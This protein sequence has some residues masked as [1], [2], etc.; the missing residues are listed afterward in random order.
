[1]QYNR[2]RQLQYNQAE[3]C[4]VTLYGKQVPIEDETT[5]LG[6]K[7]NTKCQPNIDEKINLGQ[8]TAYSLV[9]AGFQGKSGLKQSIKAD[10]WRKYV[11]PKTLFWSGI[12]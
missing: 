7:I 5:H 6:I 10:M 1:M 9:G 4:H 2:L 12:L 3:E 8:R 11:V